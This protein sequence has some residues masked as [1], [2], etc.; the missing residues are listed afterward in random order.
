MGGGLGIL[1]SHGWR[2]HRSQE[3]ALE[4]E[5]PLLS[6]VLPAGAVETEDASLLGFMHS[7]VQHATRTAQDALTR[8][9]DSKMAQQA[10][11][12]GWPS[13]HPWCSLPH[14]HLALSW[15]GISSFPEPLPI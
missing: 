8:V 14:P 13:S 6:S 3:L 12:T 11:Y 7:Y 9:Q 2:P 15:Q 5:L 1:S 10:R 4:A